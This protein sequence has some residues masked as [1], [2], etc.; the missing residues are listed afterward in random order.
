MKFEWDARKR[1]SNILKHGLD[2]AD[3]PQVFDSP[4]LN[5]IDDRRHYGE[6]RHLGMGS[7]DGR[8][9]LVVYT[10]R[11][12]TIRII[13]MRKANERETQIYKKRLDALKDD[14]ID[15]SDIPE[16]DA[17][18]WAGADLYV[19]GKKAISLRVDEDVLAFFKA[20]GKGYQT[21]IN[22]VLRQYMVAQTRGK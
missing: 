3:V 13:S 8:V 5:R 18:F 15:Y 7:L 4:M 9:V 2:F 16:T 14:A 19:G 10:L 21:A 6:V 1:A 17:A 11:G 12:N 20:Q 22:K